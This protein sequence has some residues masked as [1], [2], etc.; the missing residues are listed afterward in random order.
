[1]T[2]RHA[3]IHPQTFV[4]RLL[5]CQLHTVWLAELVVGSWS[6]DIVEWR[7]S[8]PCWVTRRTGPRAVVVCLV[9]G[10]RVTDTTGQWRDMTGG[11][12][13]RFAT[14]IWNNE[15]IYSL[16][17]DCHSH[18]HFRAGQLL[19]PRRLMSQSGPIS[20]PLKYQ[21]LIGIFVSFSNEPHNVPPP[22][23]RNTNKF[24]VYFFLSLI[25]YTIYRSNNVLMRL[26][27]HSYLQYCRASV[28][29]NNSWTSDHVAAAHTRTC[30]CQVQEQSSI[31]VNDNS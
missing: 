19:P 6:K 3:D 21:I 17:Y 14:P 31:Q 5:Q 20:H 23:S 28:L 11:V 16:Q 9:C 2:Q 12:G 8:R 18:F 22:Y 29:Y 15:L 4:I 1:M 7:D 24:T 30:G 25:M 10:G 27:N 13:K 26:V